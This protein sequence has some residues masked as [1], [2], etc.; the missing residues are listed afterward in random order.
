MRIKNLNVG[1]ESITN[2]QVQDE[3]HLPTDAPLRQPFLPQYRALDEILRR[4]SLDERL[5]AL[6]QPEV[7]DPD[8]LEP[9]VLTDLR[10]DTLS[11]FSEQAGTESGGRRETLERAAR[12][13]DEDAG[14]DNDVRTALAALLRG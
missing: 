8:M 10:L 1:V 13:L 12:I 2:W 7:L 3:V 4:P 14:L 9:S 11:I 5:P 6:L